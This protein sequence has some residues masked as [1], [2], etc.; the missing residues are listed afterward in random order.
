[1]KTIY[2]V[3]YQYIEAS[4]SIGVTNHA[5]LNTVSFY[6]ISECI[7]KNKY[8][9]NKYYACEA[10]FDSSSC[11]LVLKYHTT[12]LQSYDTREKLE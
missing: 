7:I 2:P 11:K 10:Y 9:I 6:L 4:S 3:T 1:M 8:R 12:H 5:S